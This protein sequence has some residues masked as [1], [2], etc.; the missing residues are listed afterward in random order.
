MLAAAGAIQAD[1][2]E[3]GCVVTTIAWDGN[4]LVGDRLAHISGTPTGPVR[5]VFRLRAPNGR[6][7]LVGFAGSMVYARTYLHWLQGGDAPNASAFAKAEWAVVMID[8]RRT[9]WYRCDKSDAWD[10]MGRINF[11]M[12]T[13][14]D[15]ARGAMGFGANA[16][17]ALRVS[18]KLDISS[19]VGINVVRF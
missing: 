11:A 9:V 15:I 19:G 16:R 12:G 5:K 2:A 3:G 4:E 17:Q 18:I 14:A 8:D 7:A 10:C 1:E 6:L 13:G